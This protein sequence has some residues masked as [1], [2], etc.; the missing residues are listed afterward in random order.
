MKETSEELPADPTAEPVESAARESKPDQPKG[1]DGDAGDAE[2]DD[3]TAPKQEAEQLGEPEAPAPGEKQPAPARARARA[4]WWV[5]AA[6]AVLG[7]VSLGVYWKHRQTPEPVAPTE[8]RSALGGIP[9]GSMLLVTADLRALRASPLAA[10]YLGGE[11][12][13]PGLGSLRETCGFDPIL[14]VDEIALG[15][16]EAGDADFGISALGSFSDESIIG[17]ATKVISARGG[18]PLASNIG[19]FK[20]VRDLDAPASGEIAARH[21][22]VLLLGGGGYLRNMIDA[23]D[24]NVPSARGDTRHTEQLA[25]LA[26]FET[27]RASLVLSDTQRATIA[28]EVAKSGGKA[29]PALV[30]IRAAALGVRLSGDRASL[31]AVVRTDGTSH[32]LSLASLIEESKND[33]RQ[34]MAVQMLG[35]APLLDRMKVSVDAGDIRVELDVSVRELEDVIDRAAKIRQLMEGPAKAPAPP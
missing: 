11:R 14:S 3:D 29:P 15:V 17:C 30:G 18:R 21:G 32:A 10:P 5:A 8:A 19:Q 24:G 7:A 34:G 2:P 4:W 25:L 1:D 9:Q 13:V 22:G 6:L 27:V 28:D 20:S 35:V 31:V 16:P 33:A 26:G 23:A 12:T